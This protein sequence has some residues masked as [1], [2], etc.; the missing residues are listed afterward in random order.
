MIQCLKGSGWSRKFLEGLNFW[1]FLFCLLWSPNSEYLGMLWEP[2]RT[3]HATLQTSWL[4]IHFPVCNQLTFK[5]P[6]RE[7]CRTALIHLFPRFIFWDVSIIDYLAVSMIRCGLTGH[8]LR[9]SVGHTQGFSQTAFSP[10]KLFHVG[11]RIQF[12]VMA[13]PRSS[14]SRGY[15]TP[16]TANSMA[17]YS[18]QNVFFGKN[19]NLS[20]FNT[21]F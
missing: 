10:S 13:W 6:P 14:A 12:F 19:I 3:C 2:Q 4:G 17:V 15:S 18:S 16:Q 8:L 11:G 20:S 1:S 9:V 7:H 21:V 5:R